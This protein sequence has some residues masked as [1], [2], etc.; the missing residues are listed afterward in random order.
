LALSQKQESLSQISLDSAEILV[1]KS[2]LD[3]DAMSKIN[4]K[5]TIANKYLS[6]VTKGQG[7]RQEILDSLALQQEAC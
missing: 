4:D 2:E 3:L 6:L 5:R 1:T 7:M